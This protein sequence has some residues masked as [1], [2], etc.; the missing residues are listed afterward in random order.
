ML[1]VERLYVN[2][3]QELKEALEEEEETRVS[4]EEKLESIEELN[5]EIT[6]KLTKERDHA[7][8]MVKVLKK[9]K[10]LNLE[11]F[12]LNSLSLMT[13]FKFK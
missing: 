12:M 6:A 7:L 3:V 10:R 13:N 9:R 4:L 11:L 2:D 8:S 1:V 5:N